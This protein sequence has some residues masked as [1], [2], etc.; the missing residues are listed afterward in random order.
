M[1]RGRLFNTILHLRKINAKLML[2]SEAPIFFIL[3][4]VQ[5][6][7]YRIIF[8]FFLFHTKIRIFKYE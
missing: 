7:L 5:T 4:E 6:T 8:H 3:P 1:P 2:N